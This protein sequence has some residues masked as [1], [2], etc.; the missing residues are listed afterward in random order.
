MF[1]TDVSFFAALLQGLL[2]FFSP[3]VLPLVPAYFAFL[4]GASLDQLVDRPRGKAHKDLVF[5]DL[6]DGP[7]D[8]EPEAAQKKIRRRLIL[9]TVLFCAG[10]SFVFTAFGMTTS[11]LGA[12]LLEHMATIRIAGG[13]VVIILALH[14]MGLFHIK[15]LDVEKRFH[16][17]ERPAS[18]IGMFMVGM[19]FGAGWTPCMGPFIMSVLMMAANQETALRGGALL[20]V[21]SIGLA[22]PFLILAIFVNLLLEFLAKAKKYMRFIM[23]TAGGVMFLLGVALILD[24]I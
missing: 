21:Y 13:I 3:C 8:P 24:W 22:A 16:F 23:P 11:A 5:H 10:F 12:L 1:Q 20:A 15:A 14:V 2:S 18:M 17:A 19:A 7:P 6:E 9:S 4:A